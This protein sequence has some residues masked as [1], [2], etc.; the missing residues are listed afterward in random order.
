MNAMHSS[1]RALGL[2]LA[3]G[4]SLASQARAGFQ[5]LDDGQ[6]TKQVAHDG[7]VI[8]ALKENGN[9]WACTR[10]RWE[11]IDDGTGT[12]AIAAD[13]GRVYALKDNGK[14]FRRAF[15]SWSAI[16]TKG[17]RQIA[18]AG[19][20]V[21]TLEDNE[22]VWMFDSGTGSWT[23]VDNGTRTRMI[24]AD[25]ESGLYVLKNSGQIFHHVGRGR[26]ELIDDGSGTVQIEASGGLLYALKDNGNVWRR[27]GGQWARI[28]DGAGTSQ[29][30]ADRDTLFVLKNDGRIFMFSGER[31]VQVDDGRG[32]RQIVAKEGDLVI[33]KDNGNIFLG[34]PASRASDIRVSN[35]D[36]LHGRF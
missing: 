2:A 7:Q 1:R 18:A 3:L 17:S 24:A 11:M 25:R 10:G 33:L 4:L 5:V 14:L 23:R 6:G 22:D 32:T 30:A 12:R 20:D 29:I 21:Y 34:Q 9:I 16:A 28:D 8:Y 26:F 19:K 35:F 15:G 31:W 13:A 36:A 27:A